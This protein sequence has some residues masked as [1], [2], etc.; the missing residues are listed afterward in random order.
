MTFINPISYP[1]NYN[2][3]FEAVFLATL[4]IG[5]LEVIFVRKIFTYPADY[6][7]RPQAEYEA[8]FFSFC[9]YHLLVLVLG[10]TASFLGALTGFL[11]VYLFDH[12]LSVYMEDCEEVTEEDVGEQD[13]K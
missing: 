10:V 2:F 12:M 9:V 5:L 11:C 1:E 7:G 8:M 6:E 13:E 4:A 3:L